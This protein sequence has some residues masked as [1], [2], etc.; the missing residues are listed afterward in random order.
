MAL[1]PGDS[2]A[3]LV[4]DMA[5][6]VGDR[7]VDIPAAQYLQSIQFELSTNGAWVGTVGLFDANDTGL[8]DLF[9]AAALQRKLVVRFGWDDTG[10]VAALP[11]W[12]AG[13]MKFE[14]SFTA[15]GVGLTLHV[16]PDVTL[17]ESLDRRMRSWPAG[18][19]VDE[20]FLSIARDRAWLTTGKDGRTTVQKSTTK[21][22][23]TV[24][25]GETDLAF[26][27]KYVAPY[28]RDDQG[29]GGF[30]CYLDSD[31]AVHFHNTYFTTP[32]IAARYR[33]ARSAMGDVVEFSPS[34]TSQ[35]A[36]MMGAGN[37]QYEGI[38]SLGG[39]RVEVS[40]NSRDGVPGVPTTVVR[41]A[42]HTADLGAGLH[43]R[44][45]LSERDPDLFAAAV[46]TKYEEMRRVSYTA[47][48]RVR[49]THAVRPMDFVDVEYIRPDNRRHYLSGLF[50]VHS[51]RHSLDSSGWLTEFSLFRTGTPEADGQA[52]V[53][54]DQVKVAV[55]S[56]RTHSAEGTGVD[57]GTPT[58]HAA[59]P[60]SGTPR[61][62]G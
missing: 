18:T 46:A 6:I 7:V 24:Q 11:Q 33:F 61:P 14:P 50:Q 58:R 20:V 47:V 10:G 40:A 38:D 29:R 39:V 62:R 54:A 56:A 42:T 12:V 57:G 30:R 26:V 1:N 27:N 22:P 60:G 2:L 48:L 37:T 55:E 59:R 44:R 51:L 8:E 49:G 28:A 34:D 19:D 15:Q 25:S 5:V 13:I 9:M 4:I 16:L 31:N 17:R 3:N 32:E 23:E 21:L 36:A 53:A 35:M 52:R 45:S 43:S 41:D